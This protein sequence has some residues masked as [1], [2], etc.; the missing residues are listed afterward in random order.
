[1]L[2]APNTSDWVESWAIAASALWHLTADGIPPVAMEAN[3][4]ADLTFRPWPGETLA[5]KIE[6]PQAIAGQTLTIDSSSVLVTPGTRA[7]DYQLRLS[8]RS[9]RGVDHT[10]TLPEGAS[11]QR[12]SINGQPRPIRASGR[13]LVL[14][15]TPGK[16]AIEV[17]WRI[18]QGMSLSYSSLPVGLGQASVNSR[19]ELRLPQDRWLLLASGPGVGPA[20]LFWGKLLVLIA[21]ALVLGRVGQSNGLPMRRWQW[22]VLALGLTQVD[23]WAA[24]LVVAWFFAFALR[25]KV[26]AE[27]NVDDANR[28]RRWRFNLR[29]LALVALTLALFGVLFS[30][31]EG[32]LLGQPDMQVV[33]NNSSY[34]QLN[35]YL[36][37]AAAELQGAWILSLPILVYRGLMLLWA[38]WLAWS[39]LAW[40]K[41]GWNAFGQ[42]DLWRRKAK[43][44]VPTDVQ[45]P[46]DASSTQSL[47]ESQ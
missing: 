18:D 38:L 35:W 2:A 12:V 21:V 36:D 39:L 22:V 37:R 28:G 19:T 16:Q 1:M 26:V 31:V 32:G 6:R 43:V 41:W 40:L 47:P 29:Q 46:D 13:Q 4:D 42:G 7:T 15:L 27:L 10:L 23:W 17:V 3:D 24:A 9:S 14:P 34:G 8:V 33:G 20:I 30:V 44:V 45:T 25:S 5:L 11:L